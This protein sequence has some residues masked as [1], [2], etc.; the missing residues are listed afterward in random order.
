MFVTNL[1]IQTL[2]KL[3]N[4]NM[5]VAALLLLI[6][7]VLPVFSQLLGNEK[8]IEQFLDRLLHPNNYDRRIRPFYSDS[9]GK[10]LKYFYKIAS[11]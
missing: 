5:R 3:N 6:Q 2:A 9:K 7:L 10:L 4:V 1:I 8:T 11:K